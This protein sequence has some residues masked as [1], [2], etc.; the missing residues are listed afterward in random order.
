[1]SDEPKKPED[2]WLGQAKADGWHMT[3]VTMPGV[4]DDTSRAGGR[5]WSWPQFLVAISLF[6]VSF[7]VWLVGFDS[8]F[9]PHPNP[10]LRLCLGLAPAIAFGG[11][12]WIV[13]LILR[14]FW[15]RRK[16]RE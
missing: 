2:T 4:P 13:V 16:H 3:E 11:A 6:P 12:V 8:V 1:M 14:R 9:D 15:P 5:P 10:V 7:G